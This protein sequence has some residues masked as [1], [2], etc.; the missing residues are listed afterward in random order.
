M[1]NPDE[2]TAIKQFGDGGKY[3]GVCLMLITMPGL[4][5]FGHGQIE[6]FSEKYGMEYR[7][8]YWDEKINLDLLQRHEDIIFPIMKKRYLFANANN[9]LLYDFWSG[10]VVNEDVFAYSN[11]VNN[12]RALVLYHNK[13]AETKGF[14]K[15]SVGFADKLAENKVVIQKSLIDGLTLPKEGYCIF[16]DYLTGLEYI[17]RNRDL[18]EQGL[19]LELQAYQMFVFMD[20]QIVQDN[21]FFHYAQL[22]DFLGGKGVYNINETLHEIIYQPL[23]EKFREIVNIPNFK[24]LL[25]TK[26]TEQVVEVISDKLNSF[27]IE[28]KNYSSSKKDVTRVKKEIIEKLKVISR[29]EQRLKNIKINPELT[30]IYEKMLP[31]SEVEWG[32][33]LSWLFI[34]QLGKVVSDK[35]YEL[36]SRSWFDEWRLSQFIKN[37]LEELSIKEE[38]KAQ[39][40]ISII[41]LM[42]TLQ[43]WSALNT[44][45]QKNYY[46]IFQSFFSEPEV[47]R[48]L[49]VN[50]YHNLLW[51][52]AELF[53]IF[54]RWIYLIAV[55]D[56]LAQSKESI[57]IEIEALLEDYQ[58]LK[59]IAETSKYQVNKFLESLQS[60]S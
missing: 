56:R 31:N 30:H 47:Q 21:E 57:V 50:R 32:I 6:G 34:H 45:S 19:Y 2:E 3:F 15:N 8:A 46:S 22:Y 26:K 12:E 42:V 13:F 54:V 17:R 49:N 24:D 25:N 59:K 28:V 9:F 36:Q 14:I 33:L 58:K 5:M 7:R 51:F 55:I 27:L 20:F 4:P 18:H 38:E 10:N 48:Y 40:G 11:R 44:Y 39:D 1:N 23:H 60:L 43:N 41:K 16:K 53:D 29:L 35:N 37:I 52:S